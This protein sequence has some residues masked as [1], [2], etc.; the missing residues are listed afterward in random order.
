MARTF[1]PPF[2][3][4]TKQLTALGERL[5]DARLR[6]ELTTVLFAERLG[7]SRD[8]LNRLEKG[9]PNIA[10]GTYMKALRILG[11]DQDIDQVAKDD[12][13][14]RKL[15]DRALPQRRN[16]KKSTDEQ[17]RLKNTSAP[18]S[19]SSKERNQEAI[20]QLLQG[21]RKENTDGEK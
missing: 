7:V 1:H 19:K 11:L 13:I 17:I 20:S 3:S 10:I 9:D 2:P 16:A 21:L 4:I 18:Y 15:Q 14:G 12:V 8:T 6:R 5:R